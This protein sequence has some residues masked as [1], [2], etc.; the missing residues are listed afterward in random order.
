[1]HS[2]RTVHRPT[3]QEEHHNNLV[4]NMRRKVL[5]MGKK[6]KD[7]NDGLTDHILHANTFKWIN[8]QARPDVYARCGRDI[9]LLNAPAEYE[10]KTDEQWFKDLGI[11]DFT[12]T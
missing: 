9:T 5:K 10:K 4:Q 1:M 12:P 3:Q 7:L 6:R 2:D 11:E 8:V